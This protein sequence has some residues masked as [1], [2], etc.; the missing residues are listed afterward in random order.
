MV[1]LILLQRILSRV[2]VEAVHFYE[3]F[4]SASTNE[5]VLLHAGFQQFDPLSSLL[6]C[7]RYGTLLYWLL[8]HSMETL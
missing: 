8:L 7:Y 5:K 6:I 3:R 4:F 1:N 2:V